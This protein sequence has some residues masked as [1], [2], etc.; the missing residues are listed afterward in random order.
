MTHDESADILTTVFNV[1]S[2]FL[3]VRVLLKDHPFFYVPDVIDELSSQHVLTTALVPGFPLDQATDLSQE[4]RN[5]VRP[6]WT[7]TQ[8]TVQFTPAHCQDFRGLMQVYATFLK[9]PWVIFPFIVIQGDFSTNLALVLADRSASR[10]WGCAW[11]SFL[12]SDTCRPIQTGPTSS[13]TRKLTRSVSSPS[14]CRCVIILCAPLFFF[15]TVCFC[16]SR[17]QVA[18]LDFGATRGFDKSF[19]DTYIEVRNTAAE[20]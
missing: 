10:S 1:F 6:P 14:H 17:L 12:S 9:N 16:V 15:S 5:E 20:T 2:S 4:L 13:S 7:P 11:G 19:T 3:R 8:L 18:L